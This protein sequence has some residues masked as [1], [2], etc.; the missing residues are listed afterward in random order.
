M[1]LR[2]PLTLT[3]FLIG[4]GGLSGQILL[5]EFRPNPVGTDPSSGELVELRALGGETS[6]T[7]F[8]GS[9]ESDTTTWDVQNSGTIN[10][11]FDANGYATFDT[12]D[13]E[14][15]A[16]TFF[17]STVDYSGATGIGDIDTANIVD[18][19]G[20]PD[21]V[22]SDTL[23]G[24]ALGGL[25][26]AYTGDEPQTVFRDSVT[27]DWYAVND[28]AGTDAVDLAGNSVAGT[29]FN[30]NPT[31]TVDTLGGVNPFVVPEPSTYAALIGLLA[32]GLVMIRR[33]KA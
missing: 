5:N 11:T 18:A 14:N 8:W 1:K 31:V 10:V 6:F 3:L 12:G 30:V 29:F 32:L 16:F 4:A 2:T 24:V 17:I 9:I 7:G 19:L 20:I 13:I 15:P 23:Y 27:L 26:F 28:P 22:S 25:D 21:S 33:R